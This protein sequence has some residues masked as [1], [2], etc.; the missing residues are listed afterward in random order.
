VI[1]PAFRLARLL[2]VLLAVWLVAALA[3]F[4]VHHD[5]EPRRADAVVVLQGAQ[6]RL[7]LG[8]RL[9][10]E[11]Y[12]PLLI[13]S[14]GSKQSLERRLCDGETSLAVVC[15]SADSTR[16]EAR[17]VA[18]LARERGLR[19]LDVVTSEFHVYRARKIFERCFDGELYMVG[20]SQPL[21]RLPKAILGESLKLA[22][23]TLFA[24]GC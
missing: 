21:W 3:L 5:D 9:V 11:G 10:Q 14:R 2:A 24:R 15:F 18:R 17:I 8:H 20:S 16:G 1:P 12:A 22:Y 19:R 4:V 7:P 6:S 23:Q 13:V